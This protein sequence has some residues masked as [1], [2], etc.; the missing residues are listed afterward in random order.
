MTASQAIKSQVVLRNILDVILEDKIFIV[1]NSRNGYPDLICFKDDSHFE[2][3]LIAL[4]QFIRRLP[5]PEDRVLPFEYREDGVYC[6]DKEDRLI[7][8]RRN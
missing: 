4:R 7:N 1:R 5:N 8:A 6:F 2:E 3:S